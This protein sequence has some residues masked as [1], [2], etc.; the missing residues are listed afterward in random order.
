MILNDDASD[1]DVD[2]SRQIDV[3]FLNDGKK[4]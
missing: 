4:R 2:A 1:A 3:D